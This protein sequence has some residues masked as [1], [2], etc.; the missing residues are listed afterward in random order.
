MGL[1]VFPGGRSRLH[2]LLKLRRWSWNSSSYKQCDHDSPRFIRGCPS[3]RVAFRRPHQVEV[4]KQ[5]LTDEWAKRDVPKIRQ[6]SASKFVHR[7]RRAPRTGQR[8]E[9]GSTQNKPAAEE[10]EEQGPDEPPTR[11]D[12]VA[13]KMTGPRQR[14]RRAAARATGRRGGDGGAVLNLRRGGRGTAGGAPWGT[15]AAAAIPP[16]TH[17]CGQGRSAEVRSHSAAPSPSAKTRRDG[18]LRVATGCLEYAT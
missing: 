13:R 5:E 17:L 11:D 18:A 6:L 16:S 10:E 15:P 9:G 4:L 2:N 3:R 1:I 7:G 8:T 14:Q 12:P